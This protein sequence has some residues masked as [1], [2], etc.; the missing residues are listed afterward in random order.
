M[1]QSVLSPGTVLEDG[2]GFSAWYAA[3]QRH[4]QRREAR[5]WGAS[6]L[7]VMGVA[8]MALWFALRLSPPPVLASDPPP[9][10]IAIDMEPEPVAAPT[11]PTDAPPGPQQTLSQPDPTPDPP[12]QVMAP[13]SPAPDPPVPVPK[14]EKV[15]RAPKKPRPAPVPPKPVPDRTPPAEATT[16]PP[17]VQAPPALHQAAPA[18]GQ[19]ASHVAHDPLTW[20]GA[21]LG[22]LER[23]KRYPAQAQAARQE[24]TVYLRFSMDRS[25][26]VLQAS[27]QKGAGHTLLDAETLALVRRAEP[28]P[29]PPD[30]VPGDPLTLT[31]PVEFYMDQQHD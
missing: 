28:L 24:G 13:P 29:A 19:H 30:S 26:H 1:T 12:P 7:C 18:P 3:R 27:I 21:L 9:A 20:Q 11:P 10:A 22:R 6:M 15:T 31:V 2:R 14:E 25:G 17:T 16:A 4:D 23:Y 8:G 5:L